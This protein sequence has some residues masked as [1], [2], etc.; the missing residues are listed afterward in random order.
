MRKEFKNL[1][2]SNPGNL[3]NILKRLYSM[4]KEQLSLGFNLFSQLVE[5]NNKTELNK[6]IFIKYHKDLVYSKNGN[7]HIINNLYKDEVSILTV[8]SAYIL[9]TVNKNYSSF[10][11]VISE[12]GD[13]YF[14]CD[15][16]NKDY[17]WIN[18]IKIL[19]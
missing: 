4:K 1:Y 19:V 7:E 6:N 14:V 9:V 11:S 2:S 16:N 12:F 3:Y 17:F 8:K 15:F 10:F 18:D 5:K 13:E